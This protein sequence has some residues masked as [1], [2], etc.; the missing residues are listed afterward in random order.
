MASFLF[1]SCLYFIISVLLR[2]NNI[3]RTKATPILG[4]KR[5]YVYLRPRYCSSPERRGTGKMETCTLA[6]PYRPRGHSRSRCWPETCDGRIDFRLDLAGESR[7]LTDNASIA[8]NLIKAFLP[9][10]LT[11]PCLRK[12]L[13]FCY[14]VLSLLDRRAPFRWE[15]LNLRL[16]WHADGVKLSPRVPQ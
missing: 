15:A 6:R 2:R 1:F 9:L 12:I 13:I 3:D 10:S 8:Q 11:L 4:S 5:S 16:S 7:S 14:E